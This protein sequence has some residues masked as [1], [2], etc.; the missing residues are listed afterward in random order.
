MQYVF[1]CRHVVQRDVTTERF[2]SA[3]G[4]PGSL[5]LFLFPLIFKLEIMSKRQWITIA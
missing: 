3:L 4:F 5:P 2:P 1:T